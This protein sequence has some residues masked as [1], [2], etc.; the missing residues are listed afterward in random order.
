MLLILVP[1]V[2][3]LDWKIRHVLDPSGENVSFDYPFINCITSAQATGSSSTY[4]YKGLVFVLG[5]FTNDL[6]FR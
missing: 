5:G 1:S 2:E 4:K 3:K 6:L